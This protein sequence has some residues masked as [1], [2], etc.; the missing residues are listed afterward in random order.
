M[1]AIGLKNLG[2]G[3]YITGAKALGPALM[4]KLIIDGSF[5]FQPHTKRNYHKAPAW[6]RTLVDVS[7]PLLSVALSTFLI[8]ITIL[9]KNQIWVFCPLISVYFGTLTA[10]WILSELIEAF[11]PKNN[12][13][14]GRIAER[15]PAHLYLARAALVS[16]C[17]LSVFLGIKFAS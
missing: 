3:S 1:N 8:A 6:R 14:L 5:E 13:P 10:F 9:T 4:N 15:G 2:D 17:V 7:G 11:S 12:D 16:Q